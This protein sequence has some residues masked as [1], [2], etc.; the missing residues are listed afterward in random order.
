MLAKRTALALLALAV[1]LVFATSASAATIPLV[2]VPATHRQVTLNTINNRPNLVSAV[3]TVLPSFYVQG[4]YLGAAW[5]GHIDVGC[6]VLAG[7]AYTHHVA[8]EWC[9]EIQLACDAPGGYGS[10]DAAWRSFMA[11]SWPQVD[12][13]QWTGATWTHTL[14]EAMRQAWWYP[15]YANG[16]EYRVY[17]TRAQMTTILQGCGVTP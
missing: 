15:Y 11:T 7:K 5:P 10:L 4:G 1:L 2:N 8:H 12:T 13:S 16:P 9:H 14:M 17:A 6:Y 3:A